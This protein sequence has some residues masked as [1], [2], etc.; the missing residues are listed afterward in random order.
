MPDQEGGQMSL[1]YDN[2]TYKCLPSF[3]K[4][5]EEVKLMTE[6]ELAIF[7]KQLWMEYE[8]LLRVEPTLY[9][10][11]H[12]RDVLDRIMNINKLLYYI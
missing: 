9:G 5:I 8:A 10:D 4:T 2:D 3:V 12:R 1:P 7:E 6:G 11:V